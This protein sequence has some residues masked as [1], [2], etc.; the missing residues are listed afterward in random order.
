MI[1]VAAVARALWLQVLPR[2]DRQRVA[3]ALG[4]A[5]QAA[6]AWMAFWA[7]LHDLGKASPAFALQDEA[8]AMR[9]AAAGL[10][11]PPCIDPVPHGTITAAALRDILPEAFALPRPL[12]LRVAMAVGG[13]HGVFPDGRAIDDA[14]GATAGGGE[15]WARARRMLAEAFARILEVPRAT[16]PCRIDLRTAVF[17]AGLVSVADWI[18]SIEEHFPYVMQ[19]LAPAAVPAIDL[20][21]YAAEAAARAGTALDRLGWLGWVPPDTPASFA[22]LFPGKT[23]R[24][25]QAAVVDL[26]GRLRGPA[27]VVIEAPMG[28]GKTEAALYLADHWAATYGRRGC[29]VALPTQA[30]SSQMFE[31]VKEFLG[32]RYAASWVNLQLLHGHAALS[33]A[34]REMQRGWHPPAPQGING[35]N[36]DAPPAV[37]AAVSSYACSLCPRGWGV[38]RMEG[39]RLRRPYPGTLRPRGWGGWTAGGPAR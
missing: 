38:D 9:L 8:A 24:P 37:L 25:V 1:D 28:E 4:I 10:A 39:R 34:F 3:T 33:A 12:A 36:T 22:H 29:Y 17:L 20:P 19:D 11:R 14:A 13:H 26:A 2:E 6:A 31:R 35:D 18:G 30:T 32:Q 5:P 27:L 7:A 16:P 21:R 23:P 15:S